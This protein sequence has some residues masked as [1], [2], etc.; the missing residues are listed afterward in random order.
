MKS[1]ASIVGLCA[2]LIVTLVSSSA[3]PQVPGTEVDGRKWECCK[4][5]LSIGGAAF[6]CAAAAIAE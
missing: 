5:L 2:V 3:L 1:F 4:C 6:A